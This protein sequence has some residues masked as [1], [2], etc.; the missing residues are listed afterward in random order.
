MPNDPKD[1]VNARIA[2]EIADGARPGHTDAP[3]IEEIEAMTAPA[4]THVER[5]QRDRSAKV[6]ALF[7]HIVKEAP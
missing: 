4:P 1:D 3:A 7:P 2:Q 5:L 6:R